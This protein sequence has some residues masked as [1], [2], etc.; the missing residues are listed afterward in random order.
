MEVQGKHP[1]G[2][3]FRRRLEYLLQG[4]LPTGQGQHASR[5]NWPGRWGV[6][7]HG[8]HVQG[9][10]EGHRCLH[11][12]VFIMGDD[13]KIH[14]YAAVKSESQE[15]LFRFLTGYRDRRARQGTVFELQW[16]FDDRCCR[17]AKD[18][19]KYFGTRIFPSV[20][21]APLA[22][23]FHSI[24]NLAGATTS[25]DH[26]R[27]AL[28]AKAIGSVVRSKHPPDVEAVVEYLMKGNKS[29]SR[30]DAQHAAVSKRWSRYVRTDSRP[31]QQTIDEL[32]SL[33]EMHARL[34][35][36]GRARGELPLLQ[37][38]LPPG[39]RGPR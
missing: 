6:S 19:T 27:K 37:P 2:D 4:C 23:A 34:D 16:I 25:K 1:V 7:E 39:R 26:P 24:Q 28:F 3:A 38:E 36:E 29:M 12:P 8:R 10:W 21:R 13:A 20:Q 5:D 30:A 14:G 35:A 32:R 11:M 15:Q 18:P 22:D 17:G 33:V 31:A 9:R